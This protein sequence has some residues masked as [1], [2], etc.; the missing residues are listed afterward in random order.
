MIVPTEYVPGY[1]RARMICADTADNYIA[2]T[3]ICDPIADRAME[4][5]SAFKP[6][7]ALQLI[8]AII[9]DPEDR[10]LDD[11]HPAIRDLT[12]DI[13][14]APTW[15][16]HEAFKP[17]IRLFHR[18]T[19]TTLAAMVAGALVEGFATNIAKS[20]IITGRLRESA[21]RRLRQN[22]RHMLEIF[23][24]GGL[25]ALGDGWK[26][27]VRIRFV[28][29]QIRHLLSHLDDW[30]T[31]ACGLPLHSAHLGLAIT[32]FSDRMLAHMNSLGTKYSDEEA[33]GFMAVWRYSGHLM[34]IPDTI[35]Y[36][37][38]EEAQKIYD[39]GFMCEPIGTLEST[40]MANSL[41][42]A[43]PLIAG[44]TEPTTRRSLSRYVFRVSR[45]LIGDSLAD[46]LQYPKG[47]GF[48]VLTWYRLT[49][50]YHAL[51]QK[52]APFLSR[53][54][55]FTAFNT[56][57]DVSSVDELEIRYHLPD[58]AYAEESQNW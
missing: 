54:S 9:N 57:L 13:H 51:M 34:G 33:H 45:A 41:I 56:L 40:A 2:H 43:A 28:H 21:V 26:L 3:H 25:D 22:N 52:Y 29:A 50:R 8:K 18:D 5:I 4:Q 12:H 1:E 48:G 27:S 49:R 7:E 30:D 55:N 32:V 38:R 17:G 6:A 23:L 47:R 10:V 16:D 58:S 31:P 44:I 14:T 53:E 36:K 42:Q 19:N 11:A 20:F 39:I 15:L 35:L 37:T 46:T 24:P